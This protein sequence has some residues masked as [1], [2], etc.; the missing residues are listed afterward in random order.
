VDVNQE[1]IDAVKA[2]QISEMIGNIHKSL[3]EAK[4]GP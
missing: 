2:E 1:T 4:E 3:Q